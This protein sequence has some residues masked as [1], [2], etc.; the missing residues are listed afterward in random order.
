M[1]QPRYT[2][3]GET[4]IEASVIERDAPPDTVHCSLAFIQRL[5]GVY[6]MEG[7]DFSNELLRAQELFEWE[8]GFHPDDW[9]GRHPHMSCTWLQNVQANMRTCAIGTHEEAIYRQH[10][11]H[12]CVHHAPRGCNES[13]HMC[14]RIIPSSVLLP[15]LRLP[16][17]PLMLDHCCEQKVR[18]GGHPFIARPLQGPCSSCY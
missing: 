18:I 5:I 3:L 11:C 10:C 7:N 2:V 8:I 12:S 1:L 14:P 6:G 4:I 15:S 17:F 13:C 16:I 9:R